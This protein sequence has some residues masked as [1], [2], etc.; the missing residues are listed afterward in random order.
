MAYQSQ[1][2]GIQIDDGITVNVSQNSR[3][4]TLENEKNI[5]SSTVTN[6]QNNIQVNANNIQTNANNIQTNSNNIAINADQITINTNALNHKF[7]NIAE[8]YG[9]T[10]GSQGYCAMADIHIEDT[11]ANA[12]IEFKVF[13]RGKATPCWLFVNFKNL[14]GLDPELN[15]FKHFGTSCGA[16]L[17]KVAASQWRLWVTKSEGYDS[18]TLIHYT[19]GLYKPFRITFPKVFSASKPSGTAS[20]AL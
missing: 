9:G 12:P 7:D 10:A 18:P 2:S 6:I 15:T 14:N 19:Q 1:Y 8:N 13:Q 4:E 3:L 11:Y 5:L 17:Q 16:I 20:S